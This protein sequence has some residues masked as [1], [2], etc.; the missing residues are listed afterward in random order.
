MPIWNCAAP[1]GRRLR[2]G[3]S[4]RR[5]APCLKPAGRQFSLHRSPS[6]PGSGPEVLYCQLPFYAKLGSMFLFSKTFFQANGGIMASGKRVPA[7]ILAIF[8]GVFGVHKFYLGYTKE[9]IIQIVITLV[10]CGMAGIL[11]LIEGIIY[12]T[13]SEEDFDKIY[14]EGRKGWF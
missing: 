2:Q 5:C 1:C 7:G 11:G 12:L 9:G 13:K 3:R 8:L 14:V 4:F 10:T 6:T